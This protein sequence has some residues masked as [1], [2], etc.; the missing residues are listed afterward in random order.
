MALPKVVIVGRPNVGKSSLL[1]WLA[2]RRISIVDDLAGVTRD[3]VGA[4][5]QLGDDQN[6]R[7]FELID[8]GGIGMVDR[9]DLSEDVDRQINTAMNEAGLILFVVDIR[10]E[11]MPLDEEVAQRLRY[12]K[13]PVILVMNKADYP[14]IDERGGEFYKL[15]RGKPIPVS[16]QQNRNRKALLEMIEEMLPDGDDEKPPGAVM[17]IAVVGRPNTGKST[18]INTLANAERMIVSERPG[19]TRD[20]VDVHFEL[21][22]LP[23]LAIDTAGVKRKAKIRDSLDF[24]SIHRA[25]RSIRRA[26]VV[27]MMI[28]PTQGI[29]RLDKQLADYIAKEY[30]PCIFTINKW[31]LMLMDR[32]DPSQG[33]MARFANVVQHAFRNMS[34]MPLAFI[35]AQTGKNVK[36]LLNLGQSLY[37]Q[38]NRR[39]GTGSLNRV[40]REAVLAHSP[41]MSGNRSPR[42]YYATQVGTDPPTIVLFVNSA[43]LFDP[44]YQR[45][46]LNVFREK[47]PFRDIPIKLYL[48]ARKQSEPGARTAANGNYEGADEHDFE[49]HPAKQPAPASEPSLEGMRF[50]DRE[51]NELLSDLDG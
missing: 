23:F 36:A 31:D 40:L 3:R 46:L 37:K 35:T 22:G 44:T 14:G 9:D 6:P 34:Y 42:I 19:T 47:L 4:L 43:R 30:K 51:V 5:V 39:V 32:D 15:G 17:K 33:N 12:L 8:T 27:L 24:Y 10:D 7:F 21:D 29:T 49:D 2:G 41:A 45:Y 11:L 48:R 38:A 16:C 50:L 20:S 1:N 25:E 18:F 13:T 26:D 28:D